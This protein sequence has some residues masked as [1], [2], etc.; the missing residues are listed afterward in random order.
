GQQRSIIASQVNTL[1]AQI[2]ALNQK[3]VESSNGGVNPSGLMDARDLKIDELAGLVSLQVTEQPDG[4]RS[5]SLRGGQPLVVGGRAGELTVQN[6]ADGSQTI[7]VDFALESFNLVDGRIGGQ[8]GG[9]NAFEADVLVPMMTSIT[10]M[11]QQLAD[12]VNNQLAAGFDMNGAAGQP[13]F[14]FTVS[15]ATGVLAV[16]AGALPTE[17]AFS[18]NPAEV[19]DSANLL[20]L[21]ELKSQPV[22][23]T[24]LGSVSLSDA[25]TQLVARLGMDS[26]QN[27]AGLATAQAV[28]NQAEASWKSTS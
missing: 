5:V 18:S 6:N 11:A 19:G 17:L 2:A 1:A 9:L 21:I 24:S 28:R 7:I 8:L 10:E 20:A 26:Q 15:G 12:N 16:R 4:S 27:K 14:D 13:L 3:I 25:V 23:L 22:T